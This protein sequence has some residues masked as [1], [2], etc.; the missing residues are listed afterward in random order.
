[1][2]EQVMMSCGSFEQKR[3]RLS[4]AGELTM[5]EL[6]FL[7]DDRLSVCFAIPLQAASCTHRIVENKN[8]KI[9]V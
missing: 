2:R 4:E 5:R 3:R 6:V 7:D 9:V 8:K 1:M